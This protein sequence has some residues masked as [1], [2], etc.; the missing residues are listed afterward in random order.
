MNY[1]L[2]PQYMKKL[3]IFSN[4]INVIDKPDLIK[5]MGSKCFDSEG[6]KTDTLKLVG[7]G[8]LNNYLVDTYNGKKLNLKSNQKELQVAHQLLLV[9]QEM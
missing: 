8:V 1:F 6:V 7:D 3:P 4:S 5:G 2:N 9:R